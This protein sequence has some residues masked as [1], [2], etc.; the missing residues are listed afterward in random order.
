MEPD[1]PLMDD[2]LMTLAR[3]RSQWPKV[4]FLPTASGDAD[5]YIVRF[6]RH[7]GARSGY[8][9][10]DGAALHFVGARLARV[11]ASRP[12]AKAYRMRNAGGRIVRCAL[13]SRYL[14]DDVAPTAV[15]TPLAAVA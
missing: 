5:H 12:G 7:F 2:Y 14:A 8:A 6:Y 15:E 3:E 9:V 1:N 4:C 11:V 10:E 13:T